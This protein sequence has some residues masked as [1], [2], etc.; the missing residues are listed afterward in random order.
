[1]VSLWGYGRHRRPVNLDRVRN[2][3]FLQSL[4]CS[5]VFDEIDSTNHMVR[6]GRAR[7]ETWCSHITVLVPHYR[8]EAISR[9]EG[10]G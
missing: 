6:F 3:A 1:M 4:P 2:D 10:E 8:G 9:D 7:T 5:A